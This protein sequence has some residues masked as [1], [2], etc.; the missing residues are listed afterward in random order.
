MLVMLTDVDSLYTAP[1]GSGEPVRLPLF[2]PGSEA[3]L[4]CEAPASRLNEVLSDHGRGP[5][6][7]RTRM[8][9][10]ALRALVDAS[11]SAVASGV[12]AAV[13][14]T[15]HHP[16]SL[17]RIVRGDDVGTLFVSSGAAA[18]SKL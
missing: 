13:V 16:L 11:R 1:P 4:V 6:A 12:R 10:T 17:L 2:K 5:F 7:G 14:T 3:A 18:R 8:A 15:G 9:E